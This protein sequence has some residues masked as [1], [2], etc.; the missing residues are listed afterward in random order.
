[1]TITISLGAMILIGISV[2]L[3]VGTTILCHLQGLFD[4]SS[5]GYLSGL[6]SLFTIIIYAVFWAIPSLASWAIWATW[7]RT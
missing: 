6:D 2:A 1:M 4:G 7:W 3:F 5:G